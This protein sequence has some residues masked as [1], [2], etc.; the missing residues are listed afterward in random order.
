MLNVLH[1][2][3]L[4]SFLNYMYNKKIIMIF[5][6]II[7]VPSLFIASEYMFEIYLIYILLITYM[8]LKIY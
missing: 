7:P 3:L 6:R 4:G 5:N 2:S 1:I 8:F